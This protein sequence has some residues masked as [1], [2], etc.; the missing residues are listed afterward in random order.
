M[1]EKE[2]T[3]K[4]KKTAG[5]DE[6]EKDFDGPLILPTAN[7]KSAESRFTKYR[8]RKG[9]QE[10]QA[11]QNRVARIE[12]GLEDT[13]IVDK[14]VL[15]LILGRKR[16]N[17][18]EIESQCSVIITIAEKSGEKAIVITVQGDTRESV[19]KAV[20]L[21]DY[22]IVNVTLESAAMRDWVSRDFKTLQKL[23]RAT[24]TIISFDYETAEISVKG[25]RSLV[26]ECILGINTH[27][28]YFPVHQE[29]KKVEAQLHEEIEAFTGEHGYYY[30]P[31]WNKSSH[32]GG[33]SSN[34][35]GS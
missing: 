15:G 18:S 25:R 23:A 20:N 10:Q 13:V 28:D 9:R 32:F 27:L 14:Q 4:N 11:E 8:R 17:L 22:R 2:R 19:R 21:L 35:R 31:V 7:W 34:H 33:D 1:K 30:A 26:E 6:Y 24:G 29:M 12:Q 5:E 3:K 16:S